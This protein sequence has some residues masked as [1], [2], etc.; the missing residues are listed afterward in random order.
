MICGAAASLPTSSPEEVGMSSP[1]LGRIA[2]AIEAEIR[3]R[4]LPGAVVAIGR[5]GRLVYL[6]AFGQRDAAA[7]TPMAAD[8]LFWAASMTKPLTVVAALTL[9]ER[10]LLL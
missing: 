10:G 3:A 2:P 5:R 7:G 9:H 8:A 4:R 6:E 1:R